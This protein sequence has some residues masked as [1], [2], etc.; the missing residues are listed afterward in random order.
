MKY[1]YYFFLLLILIGELYPQQNSSF[2]HLAKQAEQ[3]HNIEKA[4]A[5]YEL[6]KLY[7]PSNQKI[8][9]A[10][11]NMYVK[12]EN[13]EKG[14]QLCYELLKENPESLEPLLLLA[15][16]EVKRDNPFLAKKIFKKIL[17]KNPFNIQG[18]FGLGRLYA[19]E[20]KTAIAISL[21]H[22]LD[23]LAPKNTAVGTNLFALYF[24][25]GKFEEAIFWFNKTFGPPPFLQNHADLAGKTIIF[26]THGGLG[27]TFHFIR[28]AQYAKK[29]GANVYLR[30]D[31]WFLKNILSLCPYIDE[32]ISVNQTIPTVN[33][34][35]ILIDGIR[36]F[37]TNLQT[38]PSE[39]PYLYSDPALE[40]EWQ[41][42]TKTHKK[43][44]V[45]LCWKG[46]EC[47]STRS[48]SFELFKPLFTIPD[49][50]FY[51]LQKEELP[52]DEKSYLISFAPHFD[53]DHGSFMDTAALMKNLDLV[54]TIDTS[55]AHLA[56][57]LGIKTWT[58]LKFA[59]EWRWMLDR[60]DSPWY[61]SMKLFRQAKP[62][63]WKTV[64]QNIKSELEKITI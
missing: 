30:L 35:M 11:A 34:Q 28:Y 2:F 50:Q 14:I 45:G 53:T 33:Y 17:Q 46:H 6:A 47:D 62:G 21:F 60:T 37:N 3:S 55:L 44:K 5:Y 9:L 31:S 48:I 1:L 57:G 27:D 64:I 22:Y 15:D 8:L 10:L 42:K 54:I 61:P 25:L 24:A 40:I 59:P 13:Y 41:E 19:D 7:E 43:L 26:S 49:I 39:I 29:L 52:E 51:S 38:I 23:K 4:V 63:D 58:L 36:F 12:A 32:I 16:I 56:G 20:N 18:I